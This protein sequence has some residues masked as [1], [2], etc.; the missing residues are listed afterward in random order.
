MRTF[1]LLLIS[2]SGALAI[3]A[4]NSENVKTTLEA[5]PNCGL[6][7]RYDDNNL[8]QGF[9]PSADGQPGR[10]RVAPLDG[11]ESYELT[12]KGSV[13]D[14]SP[15]GNTVY[16]LTPESIEEW[17]LPSRTLRA[18]YS[19][20]AINGPLENKQQAEGF[21]RH[22][23][24]LIVAHGRLGVSFFNVKT[25]RLTN[26]FR[27]IKSQLPLESMAMGVTVSGD[28]AYVVMDNYHLVK[29][30]AKPPFRGIVAINMNSQTV[31]SQMDG[32]DPGA[33]GI[34]SDA[35][36][37]IVSFWG[38]PIWKYNAHH[39]KGGSIPEPEYRLWKFPV[40][41]HPTG[42]PSMDDKYYYTC[43]LKAPAYPGENG[44]L[45]KNVPMV[46]DRN[47]LLLD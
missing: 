19:T 31:T 11:S 29:P 3:A 46:L 9:G 30:P 14:I 44:G 23:D 22:G 12:A 35:K 37:V 43:Y 1:I 16:I 17:D 18:E 32:M 26:Q 10:F 8:Y 15:D 33:D 39:L 28:R 40:K 47:L 41:G 38:Q 25:K 45:Y 2:L 4:P 6:V 20:Y 27:L 36:K 42:H 7:V 24:T 21:A 5:Q 34:I 13:R